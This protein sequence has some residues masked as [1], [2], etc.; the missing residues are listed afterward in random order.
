M[1]KPCEFKSHPRHQ[2]RIIRTLMKS[3]GSYF[4]LQASRTPPFGVSV[5]LYTR[6]LRFANKAINVDIVRA[7]KHNHSLYSYCNQFTS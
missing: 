3:H 4:S 2:K 7:N 5:F 6:L 1:V